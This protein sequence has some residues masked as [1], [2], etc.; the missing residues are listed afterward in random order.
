MEL[1]WRS[2]N[3]CYGQPDM[4]SPTPSG[5]HQLR[6]SH[7]RE[8]GGCP[9]LISDESL[10]LGWPQRGRYPIPYWEGIKFWASGTPKSQEGAGVSP[11][12]RGSMCEVGMPRPSL[13]CADQPRRSGRNGVPRAV[14]GA[15]HELLD[16]FG[17]ERSP[18]KRGERKLA[19]TTLLR[20]IKE[21]TRTPHLRV[22]GKTLI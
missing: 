17:E 4:V 9:A 11:S 18:N 5:A 1:C 6:N 22:R 8:P 2:R 15:Q 3:T 13:L 21:E 16:V 19:H 7:P 10:S 14:P 12:L 20:R